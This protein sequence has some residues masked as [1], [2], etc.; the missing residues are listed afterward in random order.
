MTCQGRGRQLYLASEIAAESRACHKFIP[1]LQR[2]LT[3][4]SGPVETT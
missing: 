4:V 3:Q 1:K 2:M